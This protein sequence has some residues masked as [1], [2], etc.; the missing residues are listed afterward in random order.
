MIR[1]ISYVFELN[2]NDFVECSDTQ[3]LI[4]PRLNLHFIN[5]T[6]NYCKTP[7]LSHRDIGYHC[8]SF[9]I[10]ELS[11]NK[12]LLIFKPEIVLTR[13]TRNASRGL[14]NLELCDTFCLQT[15]LYT[16]H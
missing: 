6:F 14:N 8:H 13:L 4:I 7:K 9:I 11:I 15:G 5:M 10:L 1:T 2:K 16:V 12:K 3:L